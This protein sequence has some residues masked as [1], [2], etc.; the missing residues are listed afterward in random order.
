VLADGHLGRIVAHNALVRGLLVGVHGLPDRLVQLLRVDVHIHHRAQL[1]IL[2]LQP[3]DRALLH[4]HL[5]LQ[6]A[7]LRAQRRALQ[8]VLLLAH[9]GGRHLPA[10]VLQDGCGLV[11]Q[12]R[13]VLH[14]A[15]VGLHHVVEKL[16]RA[17]PG[18]R[19]HARQGLRV[20]HRL[21]NQLAKHR[22][23]AVQSLH[24]LLRGGMVSRGQRILG[25]VNQIIDPRVQMGHISTM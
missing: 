18:L 6:V 3:A 16:E 11:L 10:L 12:V 21:A 19:V 2:G 5:R 20:N 14:V 24:Q 9:E 13:G 23:I 15:V 22:V 4:V 1:R 8:L 17:H 25:H 7:D